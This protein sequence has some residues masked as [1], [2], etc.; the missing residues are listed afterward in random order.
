MFSNKYRFLKITVIFF[1]LI[2]LAYYGQVKGPKVIPGLKEFKNN[3]DQFINKELEFGGKIKEISSNSF[4]I[5]QAINGEKINLKIEGVLSNVKPEDNIQ[6]VA[7]YR[8]NNTLVLNRY[9][10]SNTRPI[11][12]IV[13]FIAVLWIFYLFFRDFR[14]NV[15]KLML[16]ENNKPHKS[17]EIRN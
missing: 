10:I 3:P 2:G 17:L 4:I 5:E 8:T 14:L 6:G 1:T 11:K 12:I 13:S 9:I 15:K 16:E 7:V